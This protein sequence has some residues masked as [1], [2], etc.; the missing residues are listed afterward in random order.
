MNYQNNML[1]VSWGTIV[2]KLVINQAINYKSKYK[3]IQYEACM[4]PSVDVALPLWMEIDS[5]CQRCWDVFFFFPVVCMVLWSGPQTPEL[6]IAT[7]GKQYGCYSYIL[8][9]SFP[10]L[11]QLAR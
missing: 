10:R 2:N 5:C 1:I 11:K 6:A 7:V 3:L 4:H 9:F 8:M